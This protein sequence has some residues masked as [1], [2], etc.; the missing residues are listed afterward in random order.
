MSHYFKFDDRKSVCYFGLFEF[1][2][3]VNY[4]FSS[5]PKLIAE[6]SKQII[7]NT[8][9]FE[10]FKHSNQRLTTHNERMKYFLIIIVKRYVKLFL[11]MY[12]FRFEFRFQ[13]SRSFLFK[14]ERNVLSYQIFLLCW[15]QNFLRLDI[16]DLAYWKFIF[17]TET[18]FRQIRVNFEIYI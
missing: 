3:S 1:Y 7:K 17:Y 8:I 11:I 10:K 4:F 18:F 15:D 14:N 2:E 12:N 13:I 9:S 5:S 16:I 6:L